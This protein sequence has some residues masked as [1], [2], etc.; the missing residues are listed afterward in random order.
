MSAY[1]LPMINSLAFVAY[2][3][4]RIVLDRYYVTGQSSTP[5]YAA[6]AVAGIKSVICVRQPGEPAVPPPVPSVTPFDA[7]EAAELAKLGVSYQ[8]IPI[9]R[10]MAQ[11]QFDSAATQVALAMHV[12]R[13]CGIGGRVPKPTGRLVDA[14]MVPGV[15]DPTEF[16]AYM[17]DL[18]KE[19]LERYLAAL[20]TAH[21]ESSDSS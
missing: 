8:N 5:A 20:H 7:G 15:G 9:T 21:G 1:P 19:A 3:G 6:I 18:E 14:G 16:I 12:R 13:T 11:Q 4:A 17:A 10:E 2:S